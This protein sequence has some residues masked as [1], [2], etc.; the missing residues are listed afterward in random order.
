MTHDPYAILEV[1]DTASAGEVK[2]AYRRLAALFHPDRNPGFQDAANQRLTEINEAY[3][4]IL[5]S[6]RQRPGDGPPRHSQ[7]DDARDAKR[8][9]DRAQADPAAAGRV[10]RSQIGATLSRLG[11][12]SSS[13][14]PQDNAVVETLAT[15]L[16]HGSDV[17]VCVTYRQLNITGGDD[18]F[19]TLTKSFLR[20]TPGA[21]FGAS[22]GGQATESYRDVPLMNLALCTRERLLWT[23]SYAAS[24]DG[25]VVE[26]SVTARWIPMRQI[27]GARISGWRKGV[28]E[29]WVEDGPTLTVRTTSPEA[30]ALYAHVEAAVH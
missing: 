30:Q 19:E 12:L 2:A 8:G 6:M 17:C 26:E 10:H 29:I 7:D 11:F 24:A 20:V 27:L 13:T 4:H 3:E 14:D 23:S 15:F 22:F 9:R 21:Q 5:D 18:R 1:D 25:I 28:V 16:P